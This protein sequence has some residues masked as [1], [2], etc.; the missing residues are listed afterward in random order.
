MSPR[1]DSGAV[2]V[3]LSGVSV[4]TNHGVSEAEREIGQRMVFDLELELAA[5]DAVDSDELEGTVDYGAVT[6]VLVESATARSYLT[7]ERLTAAVGDAVLDR[8]PAVGSVTV[9]ASKPE[10]PI[11]VVMDAASVELTLRR[12]A[13]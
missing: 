7:L 12:S 1:F 11:P 10:P 5:C 9:R 2:T 6:G 8:F 13:P 4:H 3:R